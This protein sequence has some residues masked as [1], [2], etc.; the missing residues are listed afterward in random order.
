MT[1]TNIDTARQKASE[2]DFSILE[3]VCQEARLSI[4]KNETKGSEQQT[5]AE[6]K[7]ILKETI[8]RGYTI[9]L[10]DFTTRTAAYTP[11]TAALSCALL[12]DDAAAFEYLA[13]EMTSG[14][15]GYSSAHSTGRPVEKIGANI[16]LCENPEKMAQLYYDFLSEVIRMK[17][18]EILCG[19]TFSTA[20]PQEDIWNR[21][22]GPIYKSLEERGLAETLIA[23]EI[24]SNMNGRAGTYYTP[25]LKTLIEKRKGLYQQGK[26]D[27]LSTYVDKYTSATQ[28]RVIPFLDLTQLQE[29]N[30]TGSEGIIARTTEGKVHNLGGLAVK[31]YRPHIEPSRAREQFETQTLYGDFSFY[32]RDVLLLNGENPFTD[33]IDLDNSLTIEERALELREAKRLIDDTLFSVDGSGT[34]DGLLDGKFGVRVVK[35]LDYKPGILVMPFIE[36]KDLTQYDEN[37]RKV[38]RKIF[39]ATLMNP[40]YDIRNHSLDFTVPIHENVELSTG[41]YGSYSNHLRENRS[42]QLLVQQELKPI[43]IKSTLQEFTRLSESIGPSGIDRNE[44][45]NCL[46]SVPD[47]SVI[48]REYPGKGID[49]YVTDL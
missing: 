18:P 13:S 49:F 38:L 7:Q 23:Q 28:K 27:A 26:K 10:A 17:D 32:T 2:N 39:N 12:L 46:L 41:S 48:V 8:E 21:W 6:A 14:T 42:V 20:V 40:E 45:L 34:R 9:P 4:L 35:P 25:V 24:A 37:E 30:T 1:M 22:L 3:L 33:R 11:R 47:S 43:D 29:E 19:N 5:L 15:I 36:G 16:L 44:V 31:M